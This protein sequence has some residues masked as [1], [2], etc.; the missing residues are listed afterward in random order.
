MVLTNTQTKHKQNFLQ[1]MI[2]SCNVG[3]NRPQRPQPR[4]TCEK[5]FLLQFQVLATW[6]HSDWRSIFEVFEIHSSILSKSISNTFFRSILKYYFKY[7]KVSVSVFLFEI[8]FQV[9]VPITDAYS[10]HRSY[11]PILLAD[12]EASQCDATYRGYRSGAPQSPI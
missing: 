9:F 4:G 7:F 3:V 10:L 5:N 1:K 6:P 12:G 11:R 8:H 2:I